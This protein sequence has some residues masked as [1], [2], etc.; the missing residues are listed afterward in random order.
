MAVIRAPIPGLLPSRPLC[1]TTWMR[2]LHPVIRLLGLCG[3]LC[4]GLGSAHAQETGFERRMDQKWRDAMAGKA[5][6]YEP[7]TTSSSVQ[8]KEFASKSANVKAFY[9]PKNFQ[10]KDFLT[11]NYKGSKNFWMGDFKYSTKT[12]DTKGNVIPNATTK[13]DTKAMPVKTWGDASKKYASK[14]YATGTSGLRRTASPP[15]DL[16]RWP[17]RKRSAGRDKWAR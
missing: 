4:L 14:T 3:A 5:K 13:Y 8:L 10:S 9:F 1:E 15:T 6:A 11:G 7:A 17:A 16:R 2:S 12:V